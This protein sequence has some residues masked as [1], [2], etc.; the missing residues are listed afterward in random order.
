M[1]DSFKLMSSP[2]A[3]SLKKFICITK[4]IF[5]IRM[6]VEQFLAPG[7]NIRFSSP[8]SVS[9]QGDQYSV[10]ITDRRILWYKSKGLVFKK[11]SFVAVPIEQVKNIVYEEK[12]LL[13]KTAI[14][15]VELASR[16]YEFSGKADSIK[17][18]Y[19]EMQAYQM[20]DKSLVKPPE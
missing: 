15:K 4:V 5:V 1:K 19:G 2:L 13:T 9:F 8:T 10:V 12:G 14:I 18:I 17:A 16:R 7:E 6:G 20:M 11:N 3:H